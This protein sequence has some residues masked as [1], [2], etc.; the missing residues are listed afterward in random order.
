MLNSI[1]SRNA[2]FGWVYCL[3]N[4][5]DTTKV[6]IGFTSIRLEDRLRQANNTFT[7]DDYFIGIAKYVRKP[8]ER[9]QAIH[10]ILEKSRYRSDREFFTVNGESDFKRVLQIFSLMDGDEHPDSKKR[11]YY[12]NPYKL[13]EKEIET[14]NEIETET[15]TLFKKYEITRDPMD[16]VNI[17]SIEKNFPSFTNLIPCLQNYGCKNKNGL[18]QGIREKNKSIIHNF[19]QFSYG[20]D[21]GNGNINDINDNNQ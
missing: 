11:L 6:K 3:I 1:N 4:P 18:I 19:S 12:R 8:Y 2:D 17:R 20:N 9:E 13:C 16:F 14:E 10:K 21:N 7:A 15:E 5:A